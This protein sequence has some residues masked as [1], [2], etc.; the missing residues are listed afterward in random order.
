MQYRFFLFF[1]FIFLLVISLIIRNCSVTF[2]LFR[3]FRMPLPYPRQCS[4]CPPGHYTA[5]SDLA[6]RRHM[7][8]RHCVMVEYLDDREVFRRMEP[9]EAAQRS[10]S[11]RSRRRGRQCR[12]QA[13]A[14]ARRHIHQHVERKPPREPTPYV[15]A[16]FLSDASST[17]SD[18]LD[19][20][21]SPPQNLDEFPELCSVRCVFRDLPAE[22]QRPSRSPS[23]ARGMPPP[24]DSA[25][26]VPLVPPLSRVFR[27]AQPS[28]VLDPPSGQPSAGPS[29]PT[30]CGA[31][32]AAATST[33]AG[34]RGDPRRRH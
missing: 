1:S 5:V 28:P 2:L 27:A 17:S 10:Q 24:P 23:A 16:G 26:S 11:I 7:I 21:T 4:E 32:A 12:Q 15:P 19:F 30:S 31:D 20:D 8:T 6:F 34:C 33:S 29:F 22:P 14:A 18:D 25:A 9:D 13:E 3:V